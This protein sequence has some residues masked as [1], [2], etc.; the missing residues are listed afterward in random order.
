MPTPPA[1]AEEVEVLWKYP[2]PIVGV[3]YS[4]DDYWHERVLLWKVRQ[5]EWYVFTPDG[6]VYPESFQLEPAN[7]PSRYRL[8]GA[9]FRYWSDLRATFRA[10]LTREELRSRIGE[11]ISDLGGEV[12]EPG[13]WRPDHVILPDGSEA[14]PLNYLGTLLGRVKFHHVA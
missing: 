10:P 13:A 8:K 14:N 2:G 6:D 1:T 11:A 5:K 4:D 9:H 12:L 7:G 3:F